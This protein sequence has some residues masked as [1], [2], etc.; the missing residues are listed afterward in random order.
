MGA[1]TVRLRDLS[2]GTLIEAGVT[3]S[4]AIAGGGATQVL[5]EQGKTIDPS[6]VE[7][8]EITADELGWLPP[9]WPA[10]P[11][12]MIRIAYQEP[13][14]ALGRVRQAIQREAVSDPRWRGMLF[15]FRR[16]GDTYV[17]SASQ[18]LADQLLR[19]VVL[20]ALTPHLT[21]HHRCHPGGR[22]RT[23]A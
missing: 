5:A 22:G 12:A 7:V 13:E 4:P 1:F 6:G 11:V 20:P 19:E 21:G 18:A 23:A 15:A 16:S 3:I 17:T 14:E 10:P 2:S 9:G 8:L